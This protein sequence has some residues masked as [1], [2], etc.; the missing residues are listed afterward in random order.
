MQ[1][2]A[3]NS[4]PD[5]GVLVLVAVSTLGVGFM[6]W[7]LIALLLDVRRAHRKLTAVYVTRVRKQYSCSHRDTP[8]ELTQ[9]QVGD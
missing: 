6:I 9:F 4:V 5:D 7:F 2:L 1:I 8:A 3:I